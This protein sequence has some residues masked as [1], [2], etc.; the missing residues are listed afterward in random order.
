M[1]YSIYISH[2]IDILAL[3]KIWAMDGNN[4]C[5]LSQ[6]G[7]LFIFNDFPHHNVI[8][9][10]LHI[11]SAPPSAPNFSLST[12]SCSKPFDS[13]FLII[14]WPF[15]RLLTVDFAV[16]TSKNEHWHYNHTMPMTAILHF[17][18]ICVV[19]LN[20]RVKGTDCVNDWLEVLYRTAYA[21]QHVLNH[22]ACAQQHGSA[23]F[24]GRLVLTQNIIFVPCTDTTWPAEFPSHFLHEICSFL[25]L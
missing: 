20:P 12:L 19:M 6:A 18:H 17:L 10:L 23:E 22:H 8:V 21:V 4:L 3:I 13:V 1:W 24:T 15:P 25:C 11:P 14:H 7:N 9:A 16:I 2:Y 5:P